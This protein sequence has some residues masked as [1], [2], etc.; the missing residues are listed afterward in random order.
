MRGTQP[1]ETARLILNRFTEEDAPAMYAAWAADPQVTRFL[2]WQP[3]RDVAETC[4][5]YTSRCV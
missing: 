1:L 4:L 2:R 3:H 5:L